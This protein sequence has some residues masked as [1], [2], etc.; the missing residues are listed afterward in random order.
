MLTAPTPSLHLGFAY[1]SLWAMLQS[2]AYSKTG[3]RASALPS[4]SLS[5]SMLCLLTPPAQQGFKIWNQAE[6]VA[7]HSIPPPMNSPWQQPNLWTT[8]ECHG[9]PCSKVVG[10]RFFVQ[11]PLGNFNQTASASLGSLFEVLRENA[12]FLI[13]LLPWN[14]LLFSQVWWP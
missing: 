13:N 5:T 2:K 1:I 10:E 11:R 14:F 4:I 3:R 7:L 6:M 12:A 8:G 9:L